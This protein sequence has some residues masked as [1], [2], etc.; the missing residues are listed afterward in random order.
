MSSL[1]TADAGEEASYQFAYPAGGSPESTISVPG[2]EP[3]GAA[4]VP[5]QYPKVS[6]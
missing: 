4:V 6:N 5:T 1:Y 2:G 3:I